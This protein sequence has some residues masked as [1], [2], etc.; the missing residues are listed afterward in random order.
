MIFEQEFDACPSL[1]LE[2][3]TFNDMFIYVHDKLETH[4]RLEELRQTSPVEVQQLIREIVEMSSGVFLWIALVVRSLLE[5]LTNL[6]S[7]SDLRERLQELPPELDDLFNHMLRSIKPKFYLQQ[8]S[9]LFQIVYHSLSPLSALALS[10]ADDKNSDL[11]IRSQIKDTARNGEVARVREISARIKTRSAGLLEVYGVSDYGI[12]EDAEHAKA[13]HSKNGLGDARRIG[14]RYL[15]LTVKEFLEKP[16]VW[17]MLLDCTRQSGFDANTALL[18]SNVMMLKSSPHSWNS[19]TWDFIHE[20][21]EYAARAENGVGMPQVALLDELDR[22]AARIELNGRDLYSPVTQYYNRERLGRGVYWTASMHEYR[23]ECSSCPESFLTFTMMHGLSL[24]VKAK[25][26]A[27]PRL[28]TY[29]NGTKARRLILEYATFCRPKCKSISLHSPL[30]AAVLEAGA[31]PNQRFDQET[32]WE[33]V[34]KFLLN[35]ANL[36]STS[37][38]H[39]LADSN[40]TV[41]TIRSDWIGIC[42]IYVLYGADPNQEVPQASELSNSITVLEAAGKIFTHLPQGPV[43]DL[44][45]LLF[46]AGAGPPSS[47]HVHNGKRKAEGK[48]FPEQFMQRTILC[49][50]ADAFLKIVRSTSWAEKPSQTAAAKRCNQRSTSGTYRG[51]EAPR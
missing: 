51:G 4:K 30:L 5:G 46:Q 38:S 7:T 45:A 49:M 18:R 31:N 28:L 25:L 34:L 48:H 12:S 16:S 22:A 39:Q 17:T 21:M 44:R 10:F 20:A 26:F 47:N 13:K 24:Y 19:T 6:D 14:V 50:E 8:A 1:R 11:A 43:D 27:D 33:R 2:N 15:H 40:H 41:R 36:K 9:R 3:L 35:Y 37:N 23:D 42:K 32:P 29:P